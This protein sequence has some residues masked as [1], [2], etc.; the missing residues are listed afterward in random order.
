[1][2]TPRPP[3]IMHS[4]TP[5]L[6]SMGTPIVMTSFGNPEDS[7]GGRT[8]RKTKLPSYLSESHIVGTPSSINRHMEQLMENLMKHQGSIYFN[9]PVDPVALGNFSIK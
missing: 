3:T 5:T 2:K 1:M 4:S 7:G 8:G 9:V 6:S